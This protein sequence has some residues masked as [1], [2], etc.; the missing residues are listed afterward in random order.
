MEGFV[1]LEKQEKLEQLKIDNIKFKELVLSDTNPFPGYYS[2][3]PGDELNKPK[4]AFAVIKQGEGCYEDLVLRAFYKIQKMLNYKFDANYGRITLHNKT[5][6]CIRFKINDFLKVPELISLFI[7]E[8]IVFKNSEKISPY[9]S[10][11]KIRKFMTFTNYAKDI[12]T[13]DKKNHYYIKVNKK[14]K[15]N[16]FAKLIL[17]IKGS[18]EF[19]TFDAAQTS[20]YIKNEIIEFVRIY[21]KSFQKDDF[22]K[23]KDEIL[24]FM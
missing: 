3:T 6:P 21:T 22:L 4:Y 19:G 17:S 2:E 5:Q 9:D 18:K 11:I 12:Y 13:G 20:L 1:C 10:N 15:W 23:L 16:N 14:Q 24:K 7:K 8:G